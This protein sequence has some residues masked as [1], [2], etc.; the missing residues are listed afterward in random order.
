MGLERKG[1]LVSGLV[2]VC[3]MVLYTG[4]G[5]YKERESEETERPRKKRE[6]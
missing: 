2:T 6:R 1:R 5:P 3:M 4:K